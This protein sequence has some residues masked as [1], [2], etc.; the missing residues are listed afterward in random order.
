MELAHPIQTHY[1]SPTLRTAPSCHVLQSV[2]PAACRPCRSVGLRRRTVGAPYDTFCGHRRGAPGAAGCP[3]ENRHGDFVATVKTSQDAA[4]QMSVL[5]RRNWRASVIYRVRDLQQLA[6]EYQRR[7]R[8]HVRRV[9]V[10]IQAGIN[11][12]QHGLGSNGWHGLTFI[13]AAWR[14]LARLLLEIEQLRFARAPTVRTPRAGNNIG[15]RALS[16]HPERRKEISGGEDEATPAGQG[17]RFRPLPARRL[18]RACRSPHPA[19]TGCRGRTSTTANTSTWRYARVSAA[20]AVRP[21][22]FTSACAGSAIG[23][24]E[25][26][27]MAS[28]PTKRP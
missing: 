1:E 18:R 7:L 14:G 26:S 23:N 11:S 15:T 6:P 27:I 22:D 10:S 8:P 28:W 25:D 3:P 17:H 12:G 21:N 9:H 24:E 19:T 20:V 13:S 2:S 16:F 4:F 5:W